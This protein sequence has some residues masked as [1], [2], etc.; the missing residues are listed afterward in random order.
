M[1]AKFAEGNRV[2]EVE[3]EKPGCPGN[4]ERIDWLSRKCGVIIMGI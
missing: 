3:G 1:S 4:G 2:L